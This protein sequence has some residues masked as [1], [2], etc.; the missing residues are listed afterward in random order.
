GH[1]LACH[2][3]DHASALKASPAEFAASVRRNG[4]FVAQRFPGYRMESFA[5][6]F[7]DVSL[8]AGK[9]L[10]GFSNARGIIPALNTS[11]ARPMLLNGVGLESRKRAE[12]DIPALIE[13]AARE[14]AWLIL[15]T[16]EVGDGPSPFGCTPGELDDV[17]TRARAA[18]LRIAPVREVMRGQASGE[19]EARV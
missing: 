5:F 6:P 2:T 3:Y 14:R 19:G 9:A 15:Y 8:T 16:H 11:P 7:G 18:G 13:Q 12:Y 1:E 10:A 17:L 4:E